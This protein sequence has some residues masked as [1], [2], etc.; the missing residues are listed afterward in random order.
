MHLV[1]IV[2]LVRA[3]C[4]AVHGRDITGSREGVEFGVHVGDGKDAGGVIEL[5]DCTIR[6][7]NLIFFSAVESSTVFSMGERERRRKDV[8]G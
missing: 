4:H 2:L 8:R 3:P 1:R 5:V 7:Q 6:Q